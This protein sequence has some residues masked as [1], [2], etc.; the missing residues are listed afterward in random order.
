MKWLLWKDYRQ[1]RLVVFTGL[2]ILFMPYLIGTGIGC[3]A[4]WFHWFA[5]GRAVPWIPEWKAVFF[6]AAMY[7]ILI[8]QLTIALIGGNAIAGERVDRSAEFLHSLPISRRRIVASKLLLA[9]FILAAVW[10]INAPVIRYCAPPGLQFRGENEFLMCLK[11]ATVSGIGFFG[12]SWFLS[13]FLNSPTFAVAGGLVSPFL[14]A[15]SVGAV[16]YLCGV[17]IDDFMISWYA[18]IYLIVAA[19]CFIAGTWYYLRRVEP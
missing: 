18:T 17:P 2:F 6:A 13:S 11:I 15:W 1:N 12:I 19:G 3:G 7:S 8:S 4:R 10:L 5:N 9:F 16:L 14:L